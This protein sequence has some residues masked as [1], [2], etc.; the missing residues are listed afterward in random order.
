[1]WRWLVQEWQWPFA[2]LFAA[3]FLLVLLPPF[4]WIAGLAVG[5]IFAQLPIYLL[6]QW[7]EHRGDR[8]RSYVNR[9][10]AGNR[11]L[12]TPGITFWINCLCVWVV[13]LV[14]IYLAI[15]ISPA[16]GLMAGYL[17]LANA[18]VHI[19]QAAIRREYN[20]GLAT[21]LFLFLPIG[22][23]CL[24]EVKASLIDHVIGFG[25]AVGGHAAIVLFLARRL[26]SLRS[27]P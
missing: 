7:E 1:M 15:F 25:L 19:I 22:G 17:T 10:I 3:V 13:D 24:W 11:E 6:H 26:M 16:A 5:L 18:V 12:L 27:S 21:A 23:W 9:V 20:P 8:F 4:A 2:S 14:A